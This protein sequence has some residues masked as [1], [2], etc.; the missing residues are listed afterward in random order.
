MSIFNIDENVITNAILETLNSIDYDVS[1]EQA[2][3]TKFCTNCGNKL[4]QGAK[5]CNKCGKKL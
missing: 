2:I 1:K 5:F 4:K 3:K